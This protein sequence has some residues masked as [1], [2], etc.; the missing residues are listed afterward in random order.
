MALG[1]SAEITDGNS[2]QQ[3]LDVLHQKDID[4][5]RSHS[6]SIW[7]ANYMDDKKYGTF[8]ALMTI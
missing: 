3:I 1:M 8:F 4:T 5:L 2:R 6:R 7:Q